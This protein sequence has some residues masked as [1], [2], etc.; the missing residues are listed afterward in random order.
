MRLFTNDAH[1]EKRQSYREEHNAPAV[2]QVPS[3]P[4]CLPIGRW[5][6]I[7]QR[8]YLVVDWN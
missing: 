3:R 4:K 6:A 8:C 5:T 7:W 2:K 1:D